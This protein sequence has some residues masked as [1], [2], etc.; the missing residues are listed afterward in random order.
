MVLVDCK[1]LFSFDNAHNRPFK[2]FLRLVKHKSNVLAYRDMG[3]KEPV[4]N[5]YMSVDNSIDWLIRLKTVNN[6][7]NLIHQFIKCIVHLLQYANDIT[8]LCNVQYVFN[9]LDLWMSRANMRNMYAQ[10]NH[11]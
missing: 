2:H 8:A 10:V 11:I 4:Q 6:K 1:I 9:E 5:G 7:E 3:W